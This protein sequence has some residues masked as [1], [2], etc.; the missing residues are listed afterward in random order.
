MRYWVVFVSSLVLSYVLVGNAF[1][2]GHQ[3]GGALCPPGICCSFWGWCGTTDLHCLVENGCQSN[4]VD[5]PDT[6]PPP[7]PETP[8]PSPDIPPGGALGDI[9]SRE[10]F[11][12]MLKYRNDPRCHAV[13]FY[14]YEAFITAAKSYPAFAS[15]GD[16]ATRKRE[17]A[18]FLGQTS[19]ETTGGWLGAPDGPYFWGY[20]Y[21]EEIGCPSHYCQPNQNFPCVPGQ[22]YCGRGPIQLSWNY[23][24]GQFGESIGRKDQLLRNPAILINNNTMS[25]ESAF[26]F[27]MT[28][29][30]PKPSCHDVITG[31]WTPSPADIAA[32]R[33]PG[34][35]VTT[36]IINGGL[37]CGTGRPDDRVQSRIGFYKRYCDMLGVS[38]GD[39]LDCYNQRPF[40][41]GRLVDSM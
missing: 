2:C 11:D 16:L 19:H 31:V 27:W 21:K 7:A 30:P 14:T 40:G 12:E 32:N 33:L 36:N 35:G 4:C 29:Q 8:P 22:S 5:G 10:M 1:Q 3:A 24:Y 20:C 38:Y 13:G 23:N 28:P 6:P 15:T 26:W 37:E 25:F 18:A 34:L 9:I 41:F 17:V 39:N